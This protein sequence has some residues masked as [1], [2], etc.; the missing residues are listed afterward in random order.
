VPEVP[1][2]DLVPITF[3]LAGSAGTQTLYT[4]VQQ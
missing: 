2:N 3:H 1:D 4:A